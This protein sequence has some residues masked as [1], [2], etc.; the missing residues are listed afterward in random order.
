MENLMFRTEDGFLYEDGKHFTMINH[1]SGGYRLDKLGD[2]GEYYFS[3]FVD[4]SS[5]EQM[6]FGRMMEILRMV[7]G[8]KEKVEL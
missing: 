7:S 5:E 6:L 8:F 4:G 1:K 2:E 3:T